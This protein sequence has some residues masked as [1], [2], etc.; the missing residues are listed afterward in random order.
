MIQVTENRQ[1]RMA[2]GAGLSQGRERSLLTSLTPG[3]PSTRVN[4][5]PGCDAGH[6][7]QQNRSAVSH[8]LLV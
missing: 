3:L 5:Y 1:E 7:R 8:E 6:R 4:R 2:Q